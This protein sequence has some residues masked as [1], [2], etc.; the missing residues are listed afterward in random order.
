MVAFAAPF[1][2]HLKN[3]HL[4]SWY[5]DVDAIPVVA[6]S[7][8]FSLQIGTSKPDGSMHL[9]GHLNGFKGLGAF[10]SGSYRV[11]FAVCCVSNRLHS[12]IY[13]INI[14]SK[15]PKAFPYRYDSIALPKVHICIY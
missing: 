15:V 13:Y 8:R 4:D 3:P 10:S 14:G 1:S 6:L 9:Y 12:H 2:K 5:T 11:D 7:F